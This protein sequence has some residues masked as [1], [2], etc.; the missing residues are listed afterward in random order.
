MDTRTWVRGMV[1]LLALTMT[2]FGQTGT[3]TVGTCATADEFQGAF[4]RELAQ[5]GRDLVR[6]SSTQSS[7]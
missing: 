6:P 4:F 1:I 7:A 3:S 2:M 5:S